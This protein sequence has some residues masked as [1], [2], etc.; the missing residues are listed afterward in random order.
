MEIITVLNAK[1]NQNNIKSAFL[2][3]LIV[4]TV[5]PMIALAEAGDFVVRLRATNIA[6]IEDSTMGRTTGRKLGTGTAAALYGN[7]YA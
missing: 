7:A 3:S 5:T 4:V 2:T 1:F 6:P